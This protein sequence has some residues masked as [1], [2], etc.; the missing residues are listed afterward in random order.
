MSNSPRYVILGK[1][2]RALR[3]AAGIATQAEFARQ[4]GASQQTV[5]R[6][7]AGTSRPRTNELAKLAATLKVDATELSHAAG[8]SPEATTVSFDRP[9]PLA[10]LLSDSF[11]YFCL[12]LLS[13]YLQGK[14]DVHPAGKTGHKQYGIDIEAQFKNGE[15]YTYQCKRESQFGPDKVKKAIKAQTIDAKKKH[16]LLSRV[17]SPDARSEIRRARGWDLWD[18]VDITRIFRNLPKREQVRIADIYFPTQR[19][20]LTGELVA[21]PWQSVDEFF[22]PLLVDGRP[23]NQRWELVGRTPEL[24]DLAC[25]L[26]DRNVIVVSL[27]GRAG[28]GKSRVLRAALEAFNAQHPEVRMVVASPTEEITA[29]SLEDLG[30][31]EKLLIIDDAHDRNDLVQ[32]IRYVADGR[33]NARLFLVYRPYWIDVV[34]GELARYALTGDLI[35]SVTLT[36]PTKRDGAILATQVL[37]KL[38]APTDTA[39]A[40]ASAAYDSPLAVVVGAQIVANEGV[41]PELFASNEVFRATVLKHYEKVIAQG[42]AQGKDQERVHK[43]LRILA[44]IQPVVPDDSHVLELLSSV[45]EVEVPDA[46]RLVRL[47]I[48]AGVL[49]KRGARYRLSPD[50]LADSIIETACITPSGASNGYAEML[51]SKSIPEHKEHVLLNLGRLD[52][53]RNEGDTSESTLLDGLWSQLVWEDDYVNAQVKAAAAAAYFQPRQALSLARRLIDEGHGQDQD[54]CRIIQGATYSLSHLT[55]ACS[56]LW[57]IGQHD[58]RT[59]HSHPN[60]AI[61]LLTELAT[62]DPRK[63]TVFV[64]HVVDFTLSL[65]DYPESW[66]GTYTPFEVFK[67]ALATEGHF[68]SAAT[69]REIMI[70]TFA[71][72]REKVKQVR[73][74]IITELLSSLSNTNQRRA[75]LAAQHL[76]DALRGPMAAQ[77]GDSDSWSDEFLGTLE[78]IDAL[79]RTVIVTAPVLVKVAESVSWHAF[80]GSECT[81]PRAQQILNHLDRDLDTRTIRALMDAWGTNTWPMEED[82]GQPQHEAD[83]DALCRELGEHYSQPALLAE[84]LHDRLNDVCHANGSPDHGS[85]RLF[86]ARLLRSNLPLARHLVQEHLRGK[87][88]QLSPHTG[89]ALSS[90]M[91]REREGASALIESMLAGD[92][93]HLQVVAEGYMSATN[94]APYSVLDL[95]ALRRIFASHEGSIVRCTSHITHE[96]ARNDKRLAIELISNT[97]VDCALRYTRD[98]FMWIVHEAT[99]PFDMVQDDQLRR[100]IGGLRHAARLD[101]HWTNEFLK[102]AIRRVPDSIIELARTRI[103]DAIASGDW[104]KQ[105]LGG[106][107]RGDRES[108]DLLS[109][110]N[111]REILRGLLDWAL[112]RIDDYAFSYRFAAL[113]KVLCSPYAPTCVEALEDWLAGGTDKH[114]KVVTAIVRDAGQRFVYSNEDFIARVLKAARYVGRKA[115]K[116]LSSAIFTASVSGTRSGAPGQPFH[117]DLEL[118]AMSEQRLA[119][120]A[121]SDPAFDL[122]RDL[123]DHAARDI[124]RQ[125]EAGR[126]MD[127]QD[128]DI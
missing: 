3:T 52:W 78:K 46:S 13:T 115:H 76:A 72:E 128:A 125:L 90:L 47:L 105:S 63:P 121:K 114:F 95:R 111:G 36:K 33:S 30:S 104:R 108:F 10:N 86:L 75:F 89:Y 49:F 27:I 32:L 73:Q 109:L 9:L 116:D 31:G 126:R 55:D 45:E 113:I 25:A 120:L 122:Y 102:K 110:S 57:E 14:A 18:Q 64:E 83:V 23:F 71:I 39:G 34:L 112:G 15:L 80:Y 85:A 68:T 22:A 12:D 59:T 42:I 92:D 69:S 2:I 100:L 29:K 93:T 50:L 54:V 24:E 21:G 60:H 61:R 65:L 81:R 44:L 40:I 20:A 106:N 88:S 118:K 84:F 82:T 58:E 41:H 99:I 53:R 28:E 62:P 96:V 8:Y 37:T 91:M 107:V 19:F 94:L 17:A 4:L 67:G 16:I 43:I 11:E 123:R 70:S 119:L 56:L 101:D 127:D 87:K 103:D 124:E 98:F 35:R 5:S 117:F 79:L 51:F 74:Q 7:E 6:W 48:D 97:D 26:A 77:P 66:T 38:G 1:Q